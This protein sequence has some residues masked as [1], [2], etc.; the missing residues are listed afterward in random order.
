MIVSNEFRTGYAVAGLSKKSGV[1]EVN[2]L[3]K[4]RLAEIL[5]M[6][7]RPDVQ[8]QVF[9]LCE[10]DSHDV[11]YL[12]V[13]TNSVNVANRRRADTPNDPSSATRPTGRVD[14]NLDA[15]AGFAA[16]HG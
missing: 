10:I 2:E 4:L 16:A 1:N 13:E 6:G 8:N 7:I 9:E 14:C 12:P 5:D 3:P 11:E 15:Q